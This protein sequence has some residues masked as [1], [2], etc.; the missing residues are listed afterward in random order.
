M[1]C[2]LNEK[3]THKNTHT[4]GSEFGRTPGIFLPKFSGVDE[5][6]HDVAGAVGGGQTLVMVG[7]SARVHQHPPFP[8]TDHGAVVPHHSD[9]SPL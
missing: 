4:D 8:Q 9:S 2:Y 1:T 5:G 3:Y 6:H 7:E